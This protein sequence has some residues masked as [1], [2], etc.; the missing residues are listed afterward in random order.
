MTTVAAPLNE[1]SHSGYAGVR[2]GEAQNPGP[3]AHEGDR[4]AEERK[5]SP[6]AHQRSGWPSTRQPR[7]FHVRS[8]ELA[9][10]RHSG[11]A[12]HSSSPSATADAQL[13][14]TYAADSS[15]DTFPVLRCG[16]DPEVCKGTSDQGLML[17]MV[18]KHGGQQLIQE[19][20]AQL[21]QLH[22][23]ACVLCDHN[24]IATV[25]S[26]HSLQK[27]ILQPE[28]SL[29]VTSFRTA[30]SLVTRMLSPSALPP[31]SSSHLAASATRRPL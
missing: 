24:P 4:A 27:K 10:D 3:A 25:Q 16:L 19:S 30:D 21:R 15:R 1:S 22:R 5:R 26:L 8:P 9:V 29:L 18:Q 11:N 31:P 17:H 7:L 28:T 14:T 12:H 2:L 20:V 6:K 23:A 13:S